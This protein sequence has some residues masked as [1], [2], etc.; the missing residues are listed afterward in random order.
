MRGAAAGA[1]DRAERADDEVKEKAEAETRR[2]AERVA[3][4]RVAAEAC[5]RAAAE[6]REKASSLRMN[7][8]KNDNDLESV[9]STSSRQNSAPRSRKTSYVS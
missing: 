3:L 7:Q 2:R 5:K 1:K 9:F 4:E 6:A 8:Q